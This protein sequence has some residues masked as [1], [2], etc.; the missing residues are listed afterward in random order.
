MSITAIKNGKVKK[1][2]EEAWHLLGQNKNG[3]ELHEPNPS[4]QTVV[5]EIQTAP[6][7][8]ELEESKTNQI[9]T[10]EVGTSTED[11][12]N[13]TVVNSI[14]EFKSFASENL[15]RGTMKDY[16]DSKNVSYKQNISND[17]LIELIASD[18]NNNIETLKATF[19][20]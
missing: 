16:L 4:N 8:N 9:V 6:V 1:F 11:E 2:S 19:N 15:K 20:L 3:W 7:K 12:S 13:Q 17:G 14:E 5:N 18:M 10:N